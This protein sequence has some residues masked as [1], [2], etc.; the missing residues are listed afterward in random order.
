MT[1]VSLSWKLRAQKA[2]A[3]VRELTER[4]AALKEKV[5]EVSQPAAPPI[6]APIWR[7]FHCEFETSERATAA[8]HFGERDDPEEFKPIC[9]WWESLNADE[10]IEALQDTLQQLNAERDSSESAE[11]KVLDLTTK[12]S[13]LS[14]ATKAKVQE[15]ENALA[16]SQSI[17]EQSNRDWASAEAADVRLKEAVRELQ[18]IVHCGQYHQWKDS[19]RCSDKLC[20][21]I[22]ELLGESP[23]PTEERNG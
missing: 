10:R 17:K 2:E 16:D 23:A 8:A 9:K 6:T 11:A 19:K 20:V 15:L 12:L 5:K 1:T 18:V 7:C 14:D 22:N 21:R 4:I 3:E 13:A